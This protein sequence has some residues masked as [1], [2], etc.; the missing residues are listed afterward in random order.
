MILSIDAQKAFDKIQQPF[1]MKTLEKVGTEDFL[2]KDH[3][4]HL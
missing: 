3:K 1:L 2:F 4:S